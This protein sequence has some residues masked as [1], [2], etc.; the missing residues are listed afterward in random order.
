MTYADW[1][2]SE[3]QR[4]WNEAM[5]RL[6]KCHPLEEWGIIAFINLLNAEYR[7]LKEVANAR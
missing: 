7:K 3:N 5:D 1:Y 6:N 4:L 2:I